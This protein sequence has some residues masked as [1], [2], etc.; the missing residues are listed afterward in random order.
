MIAYMHGMFMKACVGRLLAYPHARHPAVVCRA[1]NEAQLVP[2]D[3]N[4][5]MG[6]ICL[7]AMMPLLDRSKMRMM[8]GQ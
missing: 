4:V 6:I 5:H 8:Q 1:I 3:F 2:P 7:Y